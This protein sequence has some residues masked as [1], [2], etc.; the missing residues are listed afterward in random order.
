MESSI[1]EGKHLIIDS[2]VNQRHLKKSLASFDNHLSLIFVEATAAMELANPLGRILPSS[3]ILSET[4]TAAQFLANGNQATLTASDIYG[5]LLE[6]NVVF[7]LYG[8]TQTCLCGVQT[9]VTLTSG[10]TTIHVCQTICRNIPNTAADFRQLV[11]SIAFPELLVLVTE[12]AC[13]GWSAA[14]LNSLSLEGGSFWREITKR[15]N[16]HH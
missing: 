10:Y 1:S 8:E 12:D 2:S 5:D 7:N 11:W 9:T 16:V 13:L 15:K 3:Q 6:A 14:S 4:F